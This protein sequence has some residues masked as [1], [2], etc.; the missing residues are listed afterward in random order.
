[1]RTMQ[2]FLMFFYI[3]DQCYMKCRENDLGGFLGVIS[4]ELWEDGK[5]ID[6]AIYND[7][8]RI[9]NPETINEDNILEKTYEFLI[10]Y[11]KMFGYKFSETKQ[12]LVKLNQKNVIEYAALCTAKMYQEFNYDD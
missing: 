1:M 7:W 2:S 8:K 4:P 5:P 9:S 3:L 6:I 10:Y 11:E 12:R